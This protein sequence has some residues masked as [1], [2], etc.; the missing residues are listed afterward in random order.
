MPQYRS[1][2]D[3]ASK[4]REGLLNW[5]EDIGALQSEDSIVQDKSLEDEPTFSFLL[6]SVR[7]IVY[8]KVWRWTATCIS[9]MWNSTTAR[10]S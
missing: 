9:S 1:E 10:V 7:L 2:T 5:K 8:S 6:I 3:A 4:L